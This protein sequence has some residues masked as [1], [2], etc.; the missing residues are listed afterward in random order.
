VRLLA[1]I[2]VLFAA[3]TAL[4]S[5]RM[6]GAGG[7]DHAWL[8]VEQSWREDGGHQLYHAAVGSPEGSLTRVMTLPEKPL[9]MAAHND[10]LVIFY[11]ARSTPDG[12][13]V[14]RVRSVS[15][16]ARGP[17]GV[18]RYRPLGR[19]RAEPALTGSGVLIGAASTPDGVAA[20]LRPTSRRGPGRLMVLAEGE[21]RERELPEG[22]ET[23][24]EW[25]FGP[26]PGG[27]VLASESGSWVLDSASGWREA[28]LG[29]HPEGWELVA[30]GGHLVLG[31]WTRESGLMLSV[32]QSGR[33][34]PL[35]ELAAVPEDHAVMGLGET[36]VAYW[37]D[38]EE[39]LRLRSAAVSV[40]TGDPLYEGFAGSPGPLKQQ[41]VQF[42]ALVA[43]SVLLI[44]ILFVLRPE[45]DL[46][47]EPVLPE[48]SALAEPMSRFF[49]ALVDALPAAAVSAL[50]W[51]VPVWAAL[52]P[53][54]AIEESAGLNPI[55]LT[56]A[57]YFAHSTLGEWLF[58]RSLG[59]MVTGLRTVD[60]AGRSRVRLKQALMRNLFKAVF[61]PLT[62][63]LLLD[64]W[65]RHP[66]D[67]VAG[68]LVVAKGAAEE[69]PEEE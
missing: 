13:S 1:L 50:V 25:V 17:G 33:V 51:D 5:D 67:Q 19:G 58:G 43:G 3:A 28:A 40:N 42:I 31:K 55:F 37:F 41:D 27:A 16:G 45:G 12:G 54:L 63:L 57:I 36:I 23:G 24:E 30:A 21:W 39:T 60:V 46:Q 52:S 18:Y 14:R 22:L 47:R 44:V 20:L 59:K 15:V 11:P 62:M 56:A 10:Q 53:G 68:T 26:A 38:A 29:D 6:I 66:A 4:A 7:G 8:A 49:G 34:F 65:R 48:G 61:P 2:G 32:V 35:A 64:P 69:P 9:A